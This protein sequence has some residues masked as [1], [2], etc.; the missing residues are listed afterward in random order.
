MNIF[1]LI[2]INYV[3]N[4]FKFNNNYVGSFHYKE[5]INKI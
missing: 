4:V 2:I 3:I 1:N 5:I